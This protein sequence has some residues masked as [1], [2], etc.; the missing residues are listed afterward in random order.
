MAGGNMRLRKIIHIDLDAFFC[1]VEEL[2]HPELIGKPFAVGGQPGHRGVVSSCSYAARQFGVHSA[3]PTSQAIRLCK[4]LIIISPDHRIYS[5]KS[6]QVM[7]IL[8]EITPLV[9][10]IS[11][12]EAFLD[13]TDLPQLGLEIGRALQ[14]QIREKESLPCSVGIATNKLVAKIATNIGKSSHR[15]NTP[16]CALLEVPPGEEASFLAPLPVKELWGIGPKTTSRLNLLGIK[17]IGELAK[18]PES[19]LSSNFG[20]NG[21]D[22]A[23]HARG[24]SN[25]AVETN[26]EVKS[27]SQEVTFDQDISDQEILV[28]TLKRLSEKVS[29][30]LRKDN[31]V[32][33]TIKI[34]L[35]WQDFT[36][37]TRQVS[38]ENPTNLDSIVFKSSMA[39][40][41]NTWRPGKAVRLLGVGVS[42]LETPSQQLDLWITPDVK[43]R[44]LLS[45]LDD[46]TAR[47]GKSVIKKASRLK[48][49]DHS[50]EK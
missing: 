37:L 33:H 38:L 31:L 10:Q 44:R 3:L 13:V 32:A 19:W 25:S 26:H 12:D 24:E 2:S 29:Y 47:F 18:M 11:V 40:F 6:K 23:R 39:L 27:I 17:T 4:D 15:G 34:K 1:A 50:L 5:E 49:N 22:M 16:P 7:D 14:T 46:L 20:K 28:N 21:L 48:N 35:R 43:E 36:T 9:E 30:H 42:G 45:T 8:G 41:Q